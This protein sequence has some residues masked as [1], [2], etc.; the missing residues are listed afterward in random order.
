M[1]KDHGLSPDPRIAEYAI[2]LQLLRDN[3]D[4]GWSRTELQAEVS[5]VEPSALSSAVERLERQSVVVALDG[6]V[7]ASRCVRH[8][9]ELGLIA[10]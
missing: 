3:H 7:L 10:I 6:R 9:D 5:D 8:L 2:V 1:T 4:E